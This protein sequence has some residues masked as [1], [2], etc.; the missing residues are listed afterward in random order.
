M[1]SKSLLFAHSLIGEEAVGC[2]RAGPV[3]AGQRDR[4]SEPGIHALDQLTK[5]TIQP[6]VAETAS[7]KLFVEPPFLHDP[8]LFVPD[9]VPETGS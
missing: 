9:S 3:L 7:R 6:V 2:L 5:A 8:H 1:A 4:L